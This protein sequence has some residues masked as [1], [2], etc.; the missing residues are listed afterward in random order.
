MPAALLVLGPPDGNRLER[1]CPRTDLCSV[2]SGDSCVWRVPRNLAAVR[3][4][5][6]T[7]A[8]EHGWAFWD[9]SAAMGGACGMQ[10][11]VARDPPLGFFD[12]VHFTKPGYVAVA[13]LVF[14]DLM[15]AYDNW[16][17]AAGR[18]R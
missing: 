6:K 18:S 12:H 17:R 1:D 13:D 7:L 15:T 11:L 4:I 9:W 10:R 5:Q 2:N 14:A 8:G 3:Q 16:K